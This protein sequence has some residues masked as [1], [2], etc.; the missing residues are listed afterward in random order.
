[1]VYVNVNVEEEMKYSTKTM[2]YSWLFLSLPRS[3]LFSR[4]PFDTGLNN[5]ENFQCKANRGITLDYSS[6]STS[7]SE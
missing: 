3:A 1:M 5:L 4:C 7:T 6:S 2:Q